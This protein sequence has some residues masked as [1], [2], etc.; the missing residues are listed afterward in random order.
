MY[1]HKYMQLDRGT[2]ASSEVQYGLAE[3]KG[4]INSFYTRNRHFS[5]NHSV[6]A[7]ARYHHII[8]QKRVNSIIIS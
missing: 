5:I 1:I 3:L 7:D 2:T 4:I 6:E 8:N